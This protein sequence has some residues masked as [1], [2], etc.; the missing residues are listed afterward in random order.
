MHEYT[1]QKSA[2]VNTVRTSEPMKQLLD[3]VH[4]L[5]L[6]VLAIRIEMGGN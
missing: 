3:W 5:K 4:E 6:D 2:I 1:T